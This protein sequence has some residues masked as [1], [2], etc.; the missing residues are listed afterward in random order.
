MVLL[1]AFKFFGKNGIYVIPYVIGVWVSLVYLG[2][3]YVFDIVTG[4]FYKA[5][6]YF[7]FLNFFLSEVFLNDITFSVFTNQKL[8]GV[9]LVLFIVGA[10]IYF[11]VTKFKQEVTSA[12]ATPAPSPA[13]LNFLFNQINQ[14]PSPAPVTQ[15]QTQQKQDIPKPAPTELPLARNKT[16]S[17]FPGVLKPE[18]LQNKKAVL[19]T[20]K[21]II[22]IQIDPESPI[23][24]SNFMILAANGFYDGLKFH[25]VEPG[26]VIQ[27]GDPLG[28]GT[29][30]PGYQFS[31]EPVTRDYLRGTVAMANSG[32]NTNGSQFFILLA[33]HLELPKQYTIFGQV[34]AG[35]DVVAN[36]QVGDIIQKAVIQ[37][38]Q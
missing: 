13:T 28:D 11:T 1:F 30:G 32:P 2:E 8:L 24:A 16:L 17:Q 27:G 4:V 38:L 19:Q 23:A 12:T 34:I 36:I 25:R 10:G 21:G 20:N 9:I 14:T 26:F 37:D 22:Q 3:H 6:F 29:G 18:I 31:D 5:F 35:M 33:D 7:T 15:Q